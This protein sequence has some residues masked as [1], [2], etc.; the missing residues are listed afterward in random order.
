MAVRSILLALLVTLGASLDAKETRTDHTFHLS[1][2]EPPPSHSFDDMALLIGTWRG[3]AFGNTFEASWLPP[4]AGSMVGT[5]KLMDGDTVVFYELLVLKPDAEGR[6]GMR[7]KHFTDEFI[8]WEEKGDFVHFRFVDAASDALH[9]SGISFYRR[10][11]DAMDA[12]IVMRSG[13]DFREEKLTY[14]RVTD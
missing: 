2:G 8:A 13:E 10:G 9:F 1:E 14:R 4:S 6:F 3:T 12:Y 5:F 7:V 11:P